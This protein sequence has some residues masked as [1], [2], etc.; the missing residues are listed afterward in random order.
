MAEYFNEEWTK[1][2]PS[3]SCFDHSFY[4]TDNGASSYR[5]YLEGESEAFDLIMKEYFDGLIFF[6]NRYLHNPSVSED[7]AIDVFA[8]LVVHPKRYNFSVSLKTYLY[9]LGRS[10]ALNYLKRQRRVRIT[11]I[12]EAYDLSDGE[13]DVPDVIIGNEENRALYSAIEKLGDDMRT[14]VYLVYFEGM[15]YTEAA[16][17]MKKNKKA[18]DNLLYRAKKELKAILGENGGDR[19]E[20][21]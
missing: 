4:P 14:A 6:I 7:I 5:R 21:L 13:L 1:N 8:D 20:E 3:K 11:D 18:V 15:S 9:M 10:F 16:T 12:S 17:V 19:Y 2:N